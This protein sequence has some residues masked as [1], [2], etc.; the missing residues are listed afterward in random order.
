ML[1]QLNLKIFYK[2]YKKNNKN[3]KKL[4]VIFIVTEFYV[5]KNF[6]NLIQNHSIN[7]IKKLH[8]ENLI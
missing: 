5:L 6:S 4:K 3:K 7:L 1:I 2:L 8:S